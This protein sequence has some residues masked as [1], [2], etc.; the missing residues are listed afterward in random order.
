M[1]SSLTF[2]W[3]ILSLNLIAQNQ[4][5][6]NQT[7]V[8]GAY[9]IN[10]KKWNFRVDG[11]YRSIEYFKY[12]RQFLL[13]EI[14]TYNFNSH[15]Q[16]GFGPCFSWQYPYYGVKPVLELRPT[17]Q[18]IYKLN[19]GKI[20]FETNKPE[21]SIRLRHEL[22]YFRANDHFSSVVHRPRFALRNS[23]PIN[24]KLAFIQQ[25]ELMWQNNNRENFEFSVGRIYVALNF[26][27]KK[28]N[29]QIGYM[30]QF[31]ER[32]NNDEVDNNYLLS[33]NN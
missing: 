26:L 20:K 13:R 9:Q 19:Y 25:G 6:F 15:W 7:W 2:L 16:T 17:F 31:L 22:R 18:V 4:T 24:K 33:I 28:I 10:Y 8:S 27:H 23:F 30:F 3:V 14:S 11:S 21:F 12:N 29:Y 1:K 5:T 32:G